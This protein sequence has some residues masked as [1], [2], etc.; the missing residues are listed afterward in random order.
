MRRGEHC[1][2]TRAYIAQRK[3][4]PRR[5]ASTLCLL[6]QP[7][8]LWTLFFS[9]PTST[10]LLRIRFGSIRNSRNNRNRKE[11]QL[12][13]TL[14]FF[15]TPPP[16]PTPCSAF[17]FIHKLLVCDDSSIVKSRIYISLDLNFWIIFLFLR[18]HNIIG[19]TCC[20]IR[21]ATTVQFF[22]G[23]RKKSLNLKSKKSSHDI[24]TFSS[25]FYSRRGG[26]EWRIFLPTPHK[27]FDVQS[28]T[29]WRTLKLHVTISKQPTSG[30]KFWFIR[31]QQLWI[32]IKI[33]SVLLYFAGG[34]SKRKQK[35]KTKKF[36]VQLFII[37]HLSLYCW[38]FMT[39]E[40]VSLNIISIIFLSAFS[41]FS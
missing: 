25:D 38:R 8:H 34:A 1:I 23:R 6:R 17:A 40:I 9:T 14:S 16:T 3:V 2:Q 12:R 26:V 11:K 33:F 13:K 29:G 18:V 5:E 20:T 7:R 10:I 15:P 36:V 30:N 37:T 28:E 21:R 22:G 41:C 27:A 24:A 4:S 39:L 35:E 32:T 19:A 31:V